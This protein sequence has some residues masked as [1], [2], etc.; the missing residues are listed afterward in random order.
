[1]KKTS[2]SIQLVFLVFGSAFV[3]AQ[4]PPVVV[5]GFVVRSE[6]IPMR[7]GVKLNTRIFVPQSQSSALPIIF[8]RTPYGVARANRD[9][10][11]YFKPLVEEGF[12]FV[13][14]DIRG[15]YGSEG[16]FMMQ[17]PARPVGDDKSFDEGTDAYDTIEWLIKN[18]TQNNGR[19]GMLGV[20][21]DGWLAIMAGIEPH[22]ALKAISPQGS[23]ADMWLGDDFHH[24]GA[25]RLS[26]GF[27]Y[28]TMMETAK[29]SQQFS[30][31]RHDSF[32]WYL[33]LGPLR[34]VNDKYLKGKIPTWND[35]VAHPDYDNFWKRQTLI[36]HLRAVKVPTLNVAGWWDQEDFYGPQRIYEALE[37]HDRDNKNF[38]VVGPWNH[39]GWSRDVGN[40]LGAISFDIATGRHFREQ[41]QAQWFAHFLKDK[42]KL[43]LPEATTFESGTNRWQKWAAWP[44]VKDTE[45]RSLFMSA[46]KSLSFSKPTDAGSAFDEYISDPAHPVPYRQRPIQPTYFPAGSKWPSWLVEDQRFVD[47]RADVLSWESE[48]LENDVTIAGEVVAK[49][50][51]STSGSDADWIVKLIDVFPENHPKNWSLAGYQLMVSNEVFRGRYRN[52]F[53]KPEPIAPESIQ[54]Y[55]FSL[56]TQ[57]YTFLKGHRIMVQVQSTW[58]PL[59]DRNPQTF[60]PN[61]FEA[62]ESDFKKATH[63]IHRSAEHPSRVMIPVVIKKGE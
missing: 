48:I 2:L 60:V 9:F 8:K 61:I 28:A 24:N 57:N 35:F 47:G 12:I 27:E 56:H 33:R 32:D 10:V 26:Y 5:D 55:K 38:L 3:S 42:G 59:I 43:D 11:T 16:T 40:R 4:D 41:I 49:L 14:Q 1:M 45:N 39:G 15:K 25:F 54:E 62:K 46:N 31:D 51:A 36:P 17:R 53:E 18:V 19:V 7:D 20:S 44:P 30:F 21:Y 29:E 34:N 6:M 23:P 58:F 13:F 37:K 63:R 50:F 52:S 22:P